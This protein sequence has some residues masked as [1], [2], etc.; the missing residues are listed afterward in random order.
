MSSGASDVTVSPF[1]FISSSRL[2]PR[3]ALYY[4]GPCSF[5]PFLQTLFSFPANFLLFSESVKNESVNDSGN[6]S[7]DTQ[8]GED[9]TTSPYEINGSTPVIYSESEDRKS[10]HV[11]HVQGLACAGT[12][13]RGPTSRP[14]E[15]R[16]L[17]FFSGKQRSR[18]RYLP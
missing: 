2:R 6:I 17:F 1:G 4:F 15:F 13:F 8:Y 7:R 11:L 12:N 9:I 14:G 10:K 16:F 18:T 3:F 5:S